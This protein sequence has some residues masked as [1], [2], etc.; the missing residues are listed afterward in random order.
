[1]ADAVLKKKTIARVFG[2]WKTMH[3][4]TKEEKLKKEADS[5]LNRELA[6]LAAKYNKEID[7]LTSR[8][9]EALRSLDEAEKN[10]QDIQENLKKAFMRGVCALNFEAMSI[11]KPGELPP[12]ENISDQT[13]FQRQTE[14]IAQ[15]HPNFN[16]LVL[17]PV[18]NNTSYSED[19]DHSS[20]KKNIVFY[21]NPKV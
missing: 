2:S 14:N 13:A 4:E 9:N 8:L 3:T 15:G 16:S 18:D 19:R 7:I 6:D 17:N 11:L 1:M 5:T 10:K 20:P 21:Q 12:D